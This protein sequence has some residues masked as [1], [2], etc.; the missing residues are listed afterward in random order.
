MES[1]ALKLAGGALPIN[2]LLVLDK[3]T[4]ERLINGEKFTIITKDGPVL[5]SWQE[6]SISERKLLIGPKGIRSG[7]TQKR[8]QKA[9]TVEKIIDLDEFIRED[10]ETGCVLISTTGKETAAWDLASHKR[11]VKK[12]IE[13]GLL[14]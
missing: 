2:K 6:M 3:K 4:Q 8:A 5:K 14:D 13:A 12:M 1:V 10:A 9:S 11:S 7:V